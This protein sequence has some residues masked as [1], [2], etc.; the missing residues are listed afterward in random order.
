V[1]PLALNARDCACLLRMGF[2]I[3]G[4][5]DIQ[6]PSKY[7]H[8]SGLLSWIVSSWKQTCC[9]HCTP[10]KRRVHYMVQGEAFPDGLFS[11]QRYNL[12]R[13]KIETSHPVNV[14]LYDMNRT[15]YLRGPTTGKSTHT[16]RELNCPRSCSLRHPIMTSPGQVIQR[17]P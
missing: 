3:I 17:H 7:V 10:G 5:T 15:P 11:H 13:L 16:I 9:T 6:T 12:Y 8:E 14:V 4:E 1:Y 2:Q